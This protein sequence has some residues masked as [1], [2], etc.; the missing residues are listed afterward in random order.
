MKK[1]SIEFMYIV[2]SLDLCYTPDSVRCIQSVGNGRKPRGCEP[3]KQVRPPKLAQSRKF[4]K[5]NLKKIHEFQTTSN[6]IGFKKKSLKL[7]I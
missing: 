5:C 7:D 2:L 3:T 4:C 6:S 1:I